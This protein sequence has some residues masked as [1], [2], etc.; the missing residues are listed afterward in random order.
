ME[1]PMNDI[2]IALRLG[3]T[4]VAIELVQESLQACMQRSFNDRIRRGEMIGTFP[5][6]AEEDTLVFNHE[7]YV[8]VLLSRLDADGNHALHYAV[9]YQDNDFLTY[10][11][12]QAY[13]LGHF[14]QY[15]T[16]TSKC[17]SSVM[18]FCVGSSNSRF[19]NRVKAFY[20]EGCKTIEEKE[21]AEARAKSVISMLLH[22]FQQF[23]QDANL[24]PASFSAS[25]LLL[26]KY[27]APP[28]KN[29]RLAVMRNVTVMC[30]CILLVRYAW[31]FLPQWNLA[32][33]LREEA[34]SEEL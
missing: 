34:K 2:A 30:S 31:P 13:R 3:A 23:R 16:S 26:G 5:Y 7:V 10:L 6:L 33:S 9:Y 19:N 32:E 18:D 12:H 15:I 21:E 4:D 24:D 22:Y 11:I 1:C 29:Q 17:G 27:I 8:N 20:D 14:A 28:P 25:G